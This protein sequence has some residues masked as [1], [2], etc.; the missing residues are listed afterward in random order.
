MEST[1]FSIQRES[2]R[3]PIRWAEGQ[4]LS[5]VL[6][7]SNLA[8][9]ARTKLKALPEGGIA[10]NNLAASNILVQAQDP[11]PRVHLIDL[12]ASIT[13][14]HVQFSPSQVKATQQK[15]IQLLEVGFALL[16][17]LRHKSRPL[18]RRLVKFRQD[19]VARCHR[20]VRIHITPLGPPPTYLLATNRRQDEML[21]GL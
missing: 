18:R 12:S 10:Y 6:I 1:D 9:Q 7:S 15:V 21:A 19:V 11:H 2:P 20:R 5:L 16:S 14:P 4:F 8:D 13:L 3:H 17:K